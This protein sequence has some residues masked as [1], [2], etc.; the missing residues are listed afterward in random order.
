MTDEV[1]EGRVKFFNERR[2]F[3]FLICDKDESELFYHISEVAEYHRII[4]QDDKVAFKIDE[5]LTKYCPKVTNTSFTRELENMMAN[6]ELNKESREKAVIEAIDNLKPIIYDLKKQEKELGK[7]LSKTIKGMKQN[8]ITFDV[9]CPVCGSKLL[10]VKSRKSGKRFIG[11]SGMWENKCR[12][13]LPLPQFGTLMLS[14]KKCK[15][16]GFQIIQVKSKGK[17]PLVS[18][19]KCFVEKKKK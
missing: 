16:C 15:E 10:V 5:I 12:F 4:R 14:D 8:E 9:P 19:P 17:R 1:Y 2:G 3:G 13:S 7:E 11:C 18:C 6:I